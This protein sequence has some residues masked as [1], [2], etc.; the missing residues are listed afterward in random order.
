[1]VDAKEMTWV[2]KIEVF[3]SWNFGQLWPSL[4]PRLNPRFAWPREHRFQCH[5]QHSKVLSRG[6][7]R[8]TLARQ[9]MSSKD[10]NRR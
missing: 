8:G 2:P 4:F 1:M 10:R 5:L 3:S 6:D 7:H 9:Y